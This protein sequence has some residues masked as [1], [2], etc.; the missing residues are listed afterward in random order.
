M[1]ASLFGEEVCRDAQA[2]QRFRHALDV[3]LSPRR[4]RD[5][6]AF[7]GQRLRYAE[8]DAARGGG[9]QRDATADAEIHGKAC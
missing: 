8:P 9:D 4:N 3:S 6:R 7:G 2:V 5:A 1:T